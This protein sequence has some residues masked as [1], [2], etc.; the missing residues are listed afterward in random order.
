MGGETNNKR[1]TTQ[2]QK[3]AKHMNN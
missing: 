2:K 1:N 3:Q